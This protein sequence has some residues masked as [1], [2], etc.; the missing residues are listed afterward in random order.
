[1]NRKR[2]ITIRY[3]LHDI[4]KD[5]PEYFLVLKIVIV[6]RILMFHCVHQRIQNVLINFSVTFQLIKVITVVT[7]PQF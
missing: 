5:K 7:N 4:E 2:W 6:F 1:M 3:T